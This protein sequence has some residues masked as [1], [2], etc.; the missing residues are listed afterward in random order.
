MSSVI[1]DGLTLLPTP[2]L[3]DTLLAQ[4]N[5]LCSKLHLF[6][7]FPL[8]HLS[9]PPNSLCGVLSFQ[10]FSPS[11]GELLSQVDEIKDSWLAVAT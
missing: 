4:N 3:L 1:C 8:S 9:I 2:C 7:L 5:V 6:L 10:D 11:C